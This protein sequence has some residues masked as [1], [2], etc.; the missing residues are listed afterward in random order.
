M[1]VHSSVESVTQKYF[2]WALTA[3]TTTTKLRCGNLNV[4][5][6]TAVTTAKEKQL[7][8]NSGQSFPTTSVIFCRSTDQL[9]ETK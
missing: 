5:L 6:R 2:Y 1:N 4:D 8:I 7:T 9:S 3:S